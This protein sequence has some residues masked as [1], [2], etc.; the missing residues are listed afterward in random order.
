MRMKTAILLS[1]LLQ[2]IQSPI[3][4]R[5]LS[6]VTESP[7]EIIFSTSFNSKPKSM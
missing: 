3:S 7:T 1:K 4:I 2:F 5:A 6:L